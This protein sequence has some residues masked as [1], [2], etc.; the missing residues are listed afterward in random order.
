[1]QIYTP[2]TA[3][4][5]IMQGGMAFGQGI[6]GGLAA[7]GDAMAQGRQRRQTFDLAMRDR[8][9]KEEEE[10]K[11]RAARGK[12]ADAF[13][14]ANPDFA[15]SLG[16]TPED[17]ALLSPD[18]KAATMEGGIKAAAFAE[19]Q[20]LERQRRERLDAEAKFPQFAGML[21]QMGQDPASL[22]QVLAPEEMQRRTRA[23][24]FAGIMDASARSGYPVNLGQVDDIIK[25]SNAGNGVNWDDVRP[26]EGVTA[27]GRPYLFG[28]SGQFQLL[29][30]VGMEGG[31]A[32]PIFNELGE[33]MGH[34]V[35]G[36]KTFIKN[37]AEA[38]GQLLPVK[39]PDGTVIPG[40]GMTRDG[41]IVDRRTAAQKAGLPPAEAKQPGFLDR[42]RSAVFGAP[43]ATAAPAAP[44]APAASERVLEWDPKTRKLVDPNAP[45]A[46][47]AK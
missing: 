13:V 26:R 35:P 45:K 23:V 42:L 36:S 11:Q 46:N 8:M 37:Q 41:R 30:Q 22:P 43:E 25:A 14:K 29:P 34:Q 7:M 1:M 28:K 32:Q 27:D 9:Q 21:S 18:D 20:T 39:D 38:D 4:D 2:F 24:D 5:S 15:K 3:A 33:L 16:M 40:L 44:A 47:P 31:A 19:G 17:W 10:K 6:G 12:A